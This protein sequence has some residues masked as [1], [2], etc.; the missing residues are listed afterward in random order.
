MKEIV[1]CN[2]DFVDDIIEENV[3]RFL[4]ITPKFVA[5]GTANNGKCSKLKGWSFDKGAT[6]GICIK[7]IQFYFDG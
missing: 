1:G 3:G 7:K 5:I 4:Q 2:I 6:F